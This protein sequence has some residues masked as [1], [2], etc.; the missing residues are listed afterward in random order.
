VSGLLDKKYH[1]VFWDQAMILLL[2]KHL[3]QSESK[4]MELLIPLSE[5]ALNDD[6]FKH[7]VK[8]NVVRFKDDVSHCIFLLPFSATTVNNGS[9]ES[10]REQLGYHPCQIGI[11][12]F[13]LNRQTKG[14][15][16]AIQ[17]KF[18]RFSKKWINGNVKNKQQALKLA[19][20]IKVLEKN[21]IK[22]IAPYNSGERMR[23]LFE[24]A[25]ASFCQKQAVS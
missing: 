14:V 4:G 20:T 1:D 7:W 17:P 21:N 15:L 5:S 19:S 11:D 10:I 9:L 3:K 2:F 25:G 16:K 22:V 18:V 13:V 8:E 12:N 23:Q 24:I 6:V